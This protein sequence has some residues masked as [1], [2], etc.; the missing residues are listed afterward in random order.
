MVFCG[1]CGTLLSP[2]DVSCPRCGAVTEPDLSAEDVQTDAPTVAS[3]LSDYP[4]GVQ[5]RQAD[6]QRPA[7]PPSAPRQQK[8]VLPGNA[9]P[10]NE[11]AS[12]MDAQIYAPPTPLPPPGLNPGTLH[13]GFL[14]QSSMDYQPA[15]PAKRRRN[16][17]A[18]VLLTTLLV[19]LVIL[20][21]ATVI[22]LRQSS[23]FGNNGTP[24]PLTPSQQAQALLQRY[25]NDINNR[26][27]QNAYSLWGTDPQHPL[28]TYQQF[29]NG[30]ANTKHD[31]ITFGL[32]RPN[33]DGTVQ[34]DLTIVA[35]ETTTTGTTISTYQGSYIVGQQNGSWKILRGIFQKAG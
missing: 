29:A 3:S 34:V 26:N 27:Y 20:G 24:P 15:Q 16:G 1:Q 9:S 23:F 8:L 13:P 32:I 35:T 5:P 19:L 28:P 10:A 2:R 12:I 21:T 30:Y 11:S 14:P 18:V 4:S 7:S 22:M 31:D 6:L 33:A 17:V 25:Y